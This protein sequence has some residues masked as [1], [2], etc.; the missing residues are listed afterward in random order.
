[1]HKEVG[2]GGVFEA[3]FAASGE[4][5]PEGAGDDDIRGGF[6][7]D[8]FTAAGNVGFGGGEMGLDLREALLCL[9]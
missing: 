6:G 4:R 5:G 9:N 7:K 8:S 1:M 3:T 2:G